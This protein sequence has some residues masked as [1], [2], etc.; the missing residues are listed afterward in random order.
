VV[1]QPALLPL[2]ADRVIG[3]HQGRVIWDL[4][5]GAV[6]DEALARVYGPRTPDTS[7]STPAALAT[8][9]PANGHPAMVTR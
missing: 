9:N 4:P 3:L 6:D 2:L 8:P 5:V 1:H 7:I